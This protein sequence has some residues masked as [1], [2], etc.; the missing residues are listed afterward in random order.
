VILPLEQIQKDV[1]SIFIGYFGRAPEF[2]AMSHYSALYIDLLGQAGESATA[3]PDAFRILSEQIY[4]DGTSHGEVPAGPTVTDTWYVTH[5]Y[6]N[7]LGR[8]PDDEGLA[9]WTA[10]LGSGIVERP[11]LVALMVAAAMNDERDAAYVANRTALAIEFSDWDN[12]RP[13]I[14]DNLNYDAAQVLAG[15]DE[16]AESLEAARAK[17]YSHVPQSGDTSDDGEAP[18]VGNTLNLTV[19]LDYATTSMAFSG[20][21]VSM[22]RFTGGNETI[23][24]APGTLQRSDLLIDDSAEDSDRLVAY[25]GAGDQIDEAT[26]I[27]LENIEHLEFHF[28][29]AAGDGSFSLANVKGVQTLMLS[30]R[31]SGAIA[32]TDYT[33]SGVR[34]IDASA[35]HGAIEMGANRIEHALVIRGGAGDDILVG[36]AG[37]D[38]IEAGEGNNIID[39]GD[40]DN[41][42]SAGDGNNSVVVGRGDNVI[43]L[44]DGGANVRTGHG[45]NHIVAGKGNN[46]VRVG[47]G[48]N[49]IELGHGESTVMAGDGDNVV[50]AAGDLLI[51]VGDGNN[52][53]AASGRMVLQAGAGN[54]QV[55]AG[56]GN[57]VIA[58]EGDGANIIAL[59]ASLGTSTVSI[60]GDGNNLVD[61]GNGAFTVN[62]EGDGANSVS[63]GN[64]A[65]NIRID[66]AGGHAIV[67]GNAGDVSSKVVLL[68]GRESSNAV[69]AGDGDFE[70]YIESDGSNHVRLG[71]A[72]STNHVE[73]AGNGHNRVETGDGTDVVVI[74]GSGRNLIAT[75]A[76]SDIISI[77]GSG[78]NTIVA[79]AGA[80][81]IHLRVGGVG[82]QGANSLV[83]AQGDSGVD[84]GSHDV[85]TGFMAGHDVLDFGLVAGS[86]RNTAILTGN[87]DEPVS[88]FEAALAW[89]N[90]AFTSNVGLYYV[91]VNDDAS[92]PETSWVYVDYDGDGSADLGIEIILL[93]GSGG[94]DF[95]DIA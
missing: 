81:V 35:L 26:G 47:H 84:A 94:L 79:G 9:Y 55:R 85:I 50:R 39:A 68:N 1:A 67:L 28:L 62:I 69:E 7:V 56:D 89:A 63:L 25:F 82:A 71:T 14:L 16:T 86:L 53:I 45:N 40:G 48:N 70:V 12:S 27:E 52:D 22:F 6:R 19:Q 38:V 43:E 23:V 5:L 87:A 2:Q 57:H 88:G 4:R 10:Q 20:G 77:E 93:A 95:G 30:G 92:S 59:G 13:A 54:N 17:L 61:A 58:I 34:I 15:V 64:G 83:F 37:D 74:T 65:H 75:G 76:G 49:V 78:S 44:G 72:V 46:H 24:A 8:E 3:H 91:I 42:V 21:E 11:Q 41:R 90:E 51:I 73:L 29:N 33:H 80:D 18:A 66:G 31:I 36:G 32:L 60:K